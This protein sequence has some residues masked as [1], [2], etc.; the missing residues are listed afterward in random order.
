ME[1]MEYGVEVE[2]ISLHGRWVEIFGVVHFYCHLAKV[3]TIFAWVLLVLVFT[4]NACLS[5][6]LNLLH[7]LHKMHKQL[8]RLS[9][10][11]SVHNLARKSLMEPDFDPKS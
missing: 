11:F 2:M 3:F 8:L 7:S 6:Q 5:A 4:A 1:S 10:A 9:A